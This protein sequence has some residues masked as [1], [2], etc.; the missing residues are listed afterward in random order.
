MET[1]SLGGQELENETNNF[2]RFTLGDTV[3]NYKI[4]HD[5]K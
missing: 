3:L 1:D 5:L 4:I 2:G